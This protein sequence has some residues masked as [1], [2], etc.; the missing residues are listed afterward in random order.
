MFACDRQSCVSDN[1]SDSANE[2]GSRGRRRSRWW[3][4]PIALEALIIVAVVVGGIAVRGS[5]IHRGWLY[6]GSDSYGYLK[7]AD[8]WRHDKRLAFGPPPQPLEWYRRPVYPL[9]LALARGDAAADMNGGPGWRRIIWAQVAVEL[10]LLWPLLYLTLRR[11]AGVWPALV[12]LALAAL[13]PPGAVFSLAVLTESLAMTLAVLAIAPLLWLTRASSAWP[14]VA[15]AVG[16][17]LSA[18]L[19]PDG[20]FYATAVIPILFMRSIPYRVRLRGVGLFAAVFLLLFAPWPIRNIA[21]FGHAHLTDGMI[22]RFGNDIPNY[23]GFWN[24]MR[25][26]SRDERGAGF[27]ASCFYDLDCDATTA[28]YASLGAFEAAAT[29]PAA[30]RSVV[31]GLL[32][33]RARDG[34][35]PAMS[36]TFENLALARRR[37]HPFRVLVALPARRTARAW[38]AAQTEIVQNDA[39]WPSRLKKMIPYFRTCGRALYVAALISVLILLVTPAYRAICLVLALPLFLRSFALGWTAFSLPR[40]VAPAYPLCFMLIAIAA[41][42]LV[43]AADRRPSSGTARR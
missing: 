36:E 40:Y 24:W 5:L 38:W 8:Q 30:E 14:W 37:A 17:A 35:S 34:I 26:W 41:F 31:D 19:R 33:Q 9:F 23:R 6:A 42:V 10:L 25:T 3:T 15:A 20:V 4:R 39:A 21:Q 32:R 28:L 43:R 22:D 2:V 12:G 1:L 27:A 13:Y 7:I 16:A 11:L 29:S 18:L